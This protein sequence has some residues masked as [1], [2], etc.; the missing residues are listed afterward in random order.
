D[1]ADVT[2]RLSLAIAY[3][4][5]GANAQAVAEADQAVQRAPGSAQALNIRCWARGL[6]G[7]GLDQALAD[8]DRAAALKADAPEVYDARGFVRL[9]RGELDLALADYGRAL[10]LRPQLASARFGQGL[11]QLRLGHEAQGRPDMAAATATDPQT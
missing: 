4:G 5:R 6:S 10:R 9:R 3:G 8:C 1:P 11:A 2:A 7:E